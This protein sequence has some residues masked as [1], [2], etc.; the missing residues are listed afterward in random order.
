M[1]QYLPRIADGELR[2]R[3]EALGAVAIAGPKACGKT[4]T[5]MQVAESVIRL[6][7][8]AGAR[9]LAKVASPALFEHPTPI[10]FDE[11]QVE[12]S[13]WNQVRHQVDAR[14]GRGLYVL[15]G[16]ATPNDDVNRHSGAGRIGNVLMRPMSLFES[17]H[18]T[19]SVSLASLFTNPTAHGLGNRLD[20]VDI[21]KR[22]V[23]G[24]WPELLTADEEAARFWLDG[25]L[26]NAVEVDIPNLGSKR[27]P[28]R[29]RRLLASLARSVAQ[30]TQAKHIAADVGGANGPIAAETLGNYITALERLYLLENSPAWRPHMRSRTPLRQAEVRYFVDPSLGTAALGIGSAELLADPEALGL[31]FEALAVRDLRIYAQPLRGTVTSWR[32]AN[33]HEIDAIVSIRD[34]HWGAFEIKLHEGSADDAAASLLRFASKV[35]VSRHGEPRF[36][37]VLVAVGSGAYTRPDG[38][39]VIPLDA[40]GP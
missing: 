20:I 40:L 3:M 35:D 26:D 34:N 29:L 33:G 19:G 18:S 30:A 25:Y 37:A 38:V 16:S 28:A 7:L 14:T 5:A 32:D 2:K 13:L 17:N 36:L 31:H 15:T 4:A 6:D 11:W 12:P 24:G 10:L 22:I 23:I 9:N 21:A 1:V 39:H 27:N 8:D